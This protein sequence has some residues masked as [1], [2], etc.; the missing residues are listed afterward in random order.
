MTLEAGRHVVVVSNT[1]SFRLTY[2]TDINVAGEYSG[3]LSNGGEKVVLSLP[4]PLDAAVLR[5]EYRDTWYPATD[6]DGSALVIN[7]PLANP[8]SWSE[9]ENWHATTPSPGG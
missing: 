2:G 3:N 4:S 7:D 9:P 6:G 8:A 1:A 5:F